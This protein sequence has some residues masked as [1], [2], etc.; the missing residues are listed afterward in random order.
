MTTT[1]PQ[2]QSW[3]QAAAPCWTGGSFP[4]TQ[5]QNMCQLVDV[6]RSLTRSG[7]RW[8]LHCLHTDLINGSRR[9][10]H[11]VF[12][13]F[14]GEKR[15]LSS[16]SGSGRKTS[17]LLWAITSSAASSLESNWQKICS[18]S[19]RMTL[20]KT[21]SRPLREQMRWWQVWEWRHERCAWHVK[22][23]VLPVRHPHDD[24]IDAL[25]RRLI[26]DGLQSRDQWLAAFKTETQLASFSLTF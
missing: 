24:V 18:S 6:V 23:C 14:W 25:L 16:S 11:I 15:F 20:A 5:E 19:F 8:S 22:G 3:T 10:R 1:R 12:W 4:L 7:H 21:L 17:K 9:Q 26:D 2:C 13:G